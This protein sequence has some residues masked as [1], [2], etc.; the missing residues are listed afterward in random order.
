[1]T[2]PQIIMLSHASYVH[3]QQ[4]RT[5]SDGTP[6]EPYEGDE[7]MWNGKRIEDLSSEE[8]K[9]YLAS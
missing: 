3:Q 1:M 8:M 2:M 9:R 7:P 5:K 4:L 6:G